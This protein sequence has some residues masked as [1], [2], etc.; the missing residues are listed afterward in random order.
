M[1]LTYSYDAEGNIKWGDRHATI[2]L[3][4]HRDSSHPKE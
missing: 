2:A 4:V 1:K 3:H